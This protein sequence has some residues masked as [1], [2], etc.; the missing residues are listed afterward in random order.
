MSEGDTNSPT[1]TD[2]EEGY[3]GGVGSPPDRDDKDP[4]LPELRY[5]RG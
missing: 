4:L 3:D 2:S 5:M 1:E